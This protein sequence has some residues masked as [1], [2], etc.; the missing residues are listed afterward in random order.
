[1]NILLYVITVIMLLTLTTY[2]RLENLISVYGV[3][4]ELASYLKNES[5]DQVND[6]AADWYN[7]VAFSKENGGNQTTPSRSPANRKISWNGF[8]NPEI[9]DQTPE[10]WEAF[11]AI[12]KS[13]MYEL[14][15]DDPEFKDMYARDPHILDVLLEKITES[16]RQLH[17]EKRIVK[18][19]NLPNLDLQNPELNQLLYLMILGYPKPKQVGLEQSG[20]PENIEDEA[21]K[22]S[23]RHQISL[24]N[25]ITEKSAPQIRIFLASKPVLYAIYGDQNIVEDIIETRLSLYRRALQKEDVE[26]LK[27]EFERFRQGPY[28]PYLDFTITKTNPRDYE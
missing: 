25:F 26:G 6:A 3:K 7:L 12:S 14:F 4:K 21:S 2:L 15:K 10:T 11:K 28:G 13:L 18:V 27:Q 16:N 17:P 22:A 20:S 1:M 24:L 5:K 19:Q 23:E 8:L 9:A